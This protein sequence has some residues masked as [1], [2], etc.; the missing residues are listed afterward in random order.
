M[1]QRPLCPQTPTANDADPDQPD[2]PV[3]L[4][5][6]PHPMPLSSETPW[7]KATT[8]RKI[9][10][11]V[12]LDDK[13]DI[14][15]RNL[16]GNRDSLDSTIGMDDPFTYS[17]ESPDHA[18]KAARKSMPSTPRRQFIER[19]QNYKVSLP[20]PSSQDHLAVT[21]G[22]T[23]QPRRVQPVLK[24]STPCGNTNRIG[25]S[26]DQE[27]DLATA[28]LELIHSENLE[29]SVSTEL[30]LRHKIGLTLDVGQAKL[31]RY[32]ETISELR[33]KLNDKLQ[34]S[35]RARASDT[36]V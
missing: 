14:S 34:G 27:S 23:P 33:G 4:G 8:K 31:R 2:R 13:E 35:E 26:G 7:T 19:L 1:A 29:L 32:E 10:D 24:P 3:V 28:V 15:D 18:K 20:T 25:F 21:N 12:E 36:R 5:A 11:V 9:G 6:I 30:Q 22:A 16:G 17:G